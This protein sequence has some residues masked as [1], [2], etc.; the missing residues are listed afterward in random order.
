[1]QNFKKLLVSFLVSIFIVV[2]CVSFADGRTN[3][4]DNFTFNDDGSVN[5]RDG[6][7]EKTFS[8]PPMKAGFIVDV[9]HFD[10][11]PHMA[12]EMV[13]FGAPWIGDFALDLGVA[14]G[15]LFV[16]LD[17]E[18][19]PIIKIGPTVWVGYNV[20]EEDVSYGVGVSILDF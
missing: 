16:S 6:K 14:A 9:K 3:P 10:V 7:A 20:R 2:P 11:T 5:T 17:W 13:E 1:M 18:L 12:L 15:R 19:V 8:F 4:R